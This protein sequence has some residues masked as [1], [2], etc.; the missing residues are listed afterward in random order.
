MSNKNAIEQWSSSAYGRQF[1]S[2]EKTATDRALKSLAGPSILLQG[3]S[4]AIENLLELDFPQLEAVAAHADPGHELYT[5][6]A[7]PAYL[8][9]T[10]KSFSSAALLPS[11]HP[12]SMSNREK[13]SY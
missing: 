9:F 6:A 3:Q 12:S 11:R 5:L 1:L 7:D 8:P 10:D 13:H 2:V 4:L